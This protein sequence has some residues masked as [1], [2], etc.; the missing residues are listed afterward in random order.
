LNQAGDKKHFPFVIFHFS[1]VID[2]RIRLALGST[3]E[4]MLK[5]IPCRTSDIGNFFQ[6]QMRNEK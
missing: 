2:S 4:S 1:F 3:F 5:R 6:W